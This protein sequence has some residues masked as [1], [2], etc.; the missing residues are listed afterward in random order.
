M[1][2]HALSPDNLP[3]P[4]SFYPMRVVRRPPVLSGFEILS[5]A[6]AI[7]RVNDEELVLAVEI[8]GE[9]RAYPLN[10]MTGPEREVFNDEL[11]GR[12]IAATW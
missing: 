12:A 3:S 7:D 10:V 8:D 4:Q 2:A 5:V 6:D 11:A 1:A 9:A